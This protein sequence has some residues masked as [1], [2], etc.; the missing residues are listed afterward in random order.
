MKKLERQARVSE[1]YFDS[2]HTISDIASECGVSRQTIHK[3]INDL[4]AGWRDVAAQHLLDKQAQEL[5]RIERREAWL[6]ERLERADQ[7]IQLDETQTT[8]VPL[9]PHDEEDQETSRRVVTRQR[10]TQR[11]VLRGSP[12][13]IMALIIRND[14]ARRRILGVYTAVE[15]AG[16]NSAAMAIA[17][18]IRESRNDWRQY[19]DVPDPTYTPPDDVD[20]A[21]VVEETSRDHPRL[22]G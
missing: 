6:M 4:C 10:M 13:A 5:E 12:E 21:T 15:E 1:L 18:A 11:E 9:S 22:L 14:E 20:E 7:P 16:S 3:D 2:R 17:K 19:D 8:T